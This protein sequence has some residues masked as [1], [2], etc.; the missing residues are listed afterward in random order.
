MNWNS[1]ES[2]PLRASGQI[3]S[4]LGN[5]GLPR[6][7]I[8]TLCR[9]QLPRRLFQQARPRHCT[10]FHQAVANAAPVGMVRI[11]SSPSRARSS[12]SM[13]SPGRRTTR[14]PACTA[15][16]WPSSRSGAG[17]DLVSTLFTPRAISVAQ[18]WRKVIAY[19]GSSLEGP[20]PLLGG[21][22]PVR[23]HR[24]GAGL[25]LGDHAGGHGGPDDVVAAVVLAADAVEGLD[26]DGVG[27]RTSSSSWAPQTTHFGTVF[28]SWQSGVTTTLPLKLNSGR[29]YSVLHNNDLHAARWR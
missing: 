2:R 8:Q 13:R 24:S 22:R 15:M 1:V 14:L 11:H 16:T 26:V 29:P 10:G 27:V 18:G 5:N 20:E 19:T 21:R 7:C 12:R 28:T 17:Q 4:I 25:N 6:H 9:Q 3:T 23:H